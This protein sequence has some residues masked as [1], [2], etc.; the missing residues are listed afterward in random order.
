VISAL[1]AAEK[2]E[3]AGL[4]PDGH[5]GRGELPANHNGVQRPAVLANALRIESQRLLGVPAGVVDVLA[6]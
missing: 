2:V 1:E 6:L 3:L 5:A 4:E